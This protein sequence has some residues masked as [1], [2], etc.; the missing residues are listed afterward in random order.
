M[1]SPRLCLA[2]GLAL[3]TLSAT[4]QSQTSTN[5][6]G[7]YYATPS[8][9]QKLASATRFIVLTNW[10]GE[11]VLDRETGLVWLTESLSGQ[12]TYQQ[13][14][15][16]CIE[17]V[18]GGRAGWRLPTIQEVYRISVSG[19][20]VIADSPFP[21]MTFHAVWSSTAASGA[22]AKSRYMFVPAWFNSGISALFPQPES[23]L[24]YV[25]CVQSPAPAPTEQ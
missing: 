20:A 3:C 16:A 23:G 2:A 19:S 12:M 11:A 22:A 15:L 9:D 1:N 18:A 5:A 17:K 6:A 13:A 10:G 4:A 8:W 7:P 25:R 24:A 14:S 21:Q